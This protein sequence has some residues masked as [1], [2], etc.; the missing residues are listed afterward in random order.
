MLLDEKRQL[1]REKRI[2]EI[3]IAKLEA[4]NIAIGE[5]IAKISTQMDARMETDQVTEELKRLLDIQAQQLEGM[6]K[7]AEHGNIILVTA[8]EEKITKTSIKL[9]QRTEEIRKSAGG[10]QLARFN[11]ELADI[12]IE[13][14]EK[15]AELNVILNQ[16]GQTEN[17]LS[18]IYDP[19]IAQI[20]VAT[21]IFQKA[22][23]RLNELNIRIADFQLPT[24]TVLG[25]N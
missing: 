9:A 17:Q 1:I 8:V 13:L 10:D 6:K 5:Q 25:I 12:I 3:E 15:R 22:E 19:Q 20:R 16:L 14:A 24:V 23:N 7:S 2:A 18:A 21:K 4:C 11:N